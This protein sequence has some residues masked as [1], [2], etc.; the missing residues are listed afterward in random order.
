MTSARSLAGARALVAA[1]VAA[2]TTLPTAT[3]AD[4]RLLTGGPSTAVEQVGPAAKGD[5][6]PFRSFAL[7]ECEGGFCLADF[8]KKGNK[9]RTVHWVS[10]GI[11]TQGGILQLAQIILTD[12]DLPVA[13]VPAVSRAVSVG[14]EVATLEFTQQFEVPAGEFLRVELITDGTALG[15]QCVVAGT[16]E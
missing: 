10:C 8:G 16:I 9:I 11:N 14:G 4:G 7:A 13:F 2:L 5:P 12:P 3:L 15:S 1:A 6:K